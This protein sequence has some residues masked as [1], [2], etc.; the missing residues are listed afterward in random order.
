MQNSNVND[1]VKNALIINKD[2]FDAN[3]I[4]DIIEELRK[5]IIYNFT[6]IKRANIIDINNNNGFEI[7]LDVV[8]NIFNNIL[9]END[10]YGLV[11]LSQKDDDKKIIYGKQIFD[12]GVVGIIFDGN[13]Y[14]LIEMILRNILAFNSMIFNY[15]GYM[16][17]TNN[18]IVEIV[19]SFLEKNKFPKNLVQIFASENY[20]DLL[21]N[22]SSLDLVIAIGNRSL[23]QL[24]LS[25]SKV[26]TIVSGY[27]HFDIYVEDNKHI[28]FINKIIKLGLDIKLFVKNNLNIDYLNSFIVEDIDEAIAQ[29]NYNGNKYSTSIFT[30]NEENASKFIKEVKSKIITINT[31]PTIER[32]CDIS[33]SNLFIEKTIIYP[34]SF[35]IKTNFYI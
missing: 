10:I 12:I 9:K 28:E 25:K 34:F 27:E 35:E 1:I 29:I 23:Q 24:V 5:N 6:L 20:D 26:K 22:Y 17:G 8:N 30:S 4:K 21:S 11:T 31:S 32:I 3:I 7:D 16:Y 2:G 14:V 19:N 13:P 33:Q 15:S 18:S